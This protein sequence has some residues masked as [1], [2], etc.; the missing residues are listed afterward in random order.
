M[1]YTKT[2]LGMIHADIGS[3]KLTFMINLEHLG[4]ATIELL[5][6]FCM[7]V[8]VRHLLIIF[9]ADKRVWPI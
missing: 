1:K 4:F 8:V 7:E 2:R 9:P 6:L 3:A 5:T